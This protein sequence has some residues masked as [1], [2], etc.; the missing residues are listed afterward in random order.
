MNDLSETATVAPPLADSIQIESV[1]TR[2]IN[3]AR[4][5]GALELIAAYRPTSRARQCLRQ[6]AAGL[7]AEPRPRALAAIGP[8]GVGKS[9]FALFAGALLSDPGSEAHQTA[10][11][12]LQ[13]ADPELAE[14]ITQ[15]LSGNASHTASDPANRAASNNTVNLRVFSPSLLLRS[16]GHQARSACEIACSAPLPKYSL[17]RSS[18]KSL[19]RG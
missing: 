4:D 7:S 11:R 14:Q 17:M 19:N 13:A 16:L 10:A 6:L 1:Y 5:G 12:V 2:A 9:A 8:Y 18:A 15:A 3:L